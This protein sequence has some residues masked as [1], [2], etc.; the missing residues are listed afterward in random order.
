MR[1]KFFITIFL[2]AILLFS[3]H[4][5]YSRNATGRSKEAPAISLDEIDKI[6]DSLIIRG[7]EIDP[8]E[9]VHDEELDMS[10]GEI[11]YDD[12]FDGTI[13]DNTQKKTKRRVKRKK[14]SDNSASGSTILGQL[15]KKD[16]R[17]HL[18]RHKIKKNENLWVISRKYKID[19]KLIIR[20][21]KIRNPDRLRAGKTILIPN[22][23]GID[24]RLVRGDTIKKIAKKYRVSRNIILSHNSIK[25]PG[26]IISGKK[27]FLPDAS[28]LKKTRRKTVFRYAQKKAKTKSTVRYVQK[29]PAHNR[30]VSH[31]RRIFSWPLRGPITSSFGRRIHPFSKKRGFHCG[32]DIGAI[33]GTPIRAALSGRVIYSG[34]KAGYGKVVILKH[35]NGYIT[36]YAHNK[37]NLVKKDKKVSRGQLIAKSG[38]TGLATGGHLHF[39]IRKYLTPLNPMR[40]LKL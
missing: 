35:A 31:A 11:I 24:Y 15:R 38:M 30:K 14:K 21:N 3:F 1:N 5:V 9:S 8:E 18:S 7:L 19:Y 32:L 28:P 13:S 6:E 37:K 25:N 22:K 2:L 17:W 27:I 26:K 40:L 12:S 36:V 4:F 29:K 34:W 39:E 23:R 20:I 16:R 33:I 10:S